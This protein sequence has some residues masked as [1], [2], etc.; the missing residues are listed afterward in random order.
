MTDDFARWRNALAGQPMDFGAKN[1]PACGYYRNLTPKGI[2]AVGIFKEG[3]EI[4]CWRNVYGDG[5]KMSIDEIDE[6]FGNVGRYP[7]PY[8][9][10]NHAA[11]GGEWP[12]EYGTRLTMKEIQANVAWTPEYGRKKLGADLEKYDED[13]NERPG[14]G[15]NNPP[16]DLTPDKAL[17]K[18][19]LDLGTQLG[20]WLKQ[21]GGTVTTQAEADVLGN[22]ANKF[23]D[24]ENE[25]VAAHKAEKAPYLEK[26]REIDSKWF[27]PVKDKA[28]ASRDKVI[29][30]IR[31]FEA[32]ENAKRVEAARLANEAARAAAQTQARIDD[33]L[34]SAMPEIVPDASKVTT[35]RGGSRKPTGPLVIDLPAF[36]AH[37]AAMDSLPPDIVDAAEKVARKWRSAGICAPGMEKKVS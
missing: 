34:V 28:I 16:E 35:L 24:F 25:A 31:S 7:I 1:D 33:A 4:K 2:E 23:K 15:H 10:F 21:I 37:C 9:I 32:A 27:A 19:I 18:R 3:D 8:E 14:L 5:S 22:Y 6:L 12:A 20:T 29:A 17:A 30:M 13:G 26:S 36:L 11:S